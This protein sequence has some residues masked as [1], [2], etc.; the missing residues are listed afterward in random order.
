MA[1]EYEYI[2][3][4]GIGN[5]GDSINT[6]Q[7]YN[8]IGPRM[9]GG[10]QTAANLAFNETK[11]RTACT[12]KRLLVHVPTNARPDICTVTVLKN[13]VAT[14]LTV[15]IPA[16]ATGNF[17][18]TTDSVSFAAGDTICYSITFAAVDAS[19]I[20]VDAFSFIA[21]P[22]SP[23]FSVGYFIGGFEALNAG[24][25]TQY[26]NIF[27][28]VQG[29]LIAIAEG[30]WQYKV[31][32]AQT[33]S[34]LSLYIP[35][36]GNGLTVN[37]PVKLR[38]NGVDTALSVTIPGG[39]VSPG[40]LE[41]NVNSV[42]LVPGDLVDIVVYSDVADIGKIVSWGHLHMES[43]G[44]GFRIVG[45]TFQP[46]NSSGFNTGASYYCYAEQDPQQANNADTTELKTRLTSATIRNLQVLTD[47]S[48][49]SNTSTKAFTITVMKNGAATSETV[50]VGA[51]AFGLQEDLANTVPLVSGNTYSIRFNSAAGAG[52]FAPSIVACEIGKDVGDLTLVKTAT[53]GNAT[54]TFKVEGP[55]GPGAIANQTILTVAGTGTVTVSGVAAGPYT[56]TEVSS[57]WGWGS[58]GANPQTVT[59]PSGG[60]GTLTFTNTYGP[61]GGG[62][63]G[64]RGPTPTGTTS[65]KVFQHG[66]KGYA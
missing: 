60:T 30:D 40:L 39:N 47:P 12:V 53:G 57:P 1:L 42:S 11:L 8:A 20:L 58:T 62:I 52:F 51:G 49:D 64:K 29:N 24:M 50:T 2:V 4:N 55:D 36:N 23:A 61:H 27:G 3:T 43:T 5:Y 63:G 21:S 15:A 13:G 9:N 59:V 65:P 66:L 17:E 10:N 33:W 25:L 7:Y 41:D 19:S 37:T 26:Y 34:K 14:A 22:A 38:K 45:M 28:G 48:A 44:S 56:V 6:A 31:K 16:G 54:F 35:A 32:T 18:D 46:A